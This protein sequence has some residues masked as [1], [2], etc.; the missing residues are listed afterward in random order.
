[1]LLKLFK[2]SFISVFLFS[3]ISY[4]STSDSFCYSQQL[5]FG[6]HPSGA[7]VTSFCF[8]TKSSWGGSTSKEVSQKVCDQWSQFLNLEHPL[9]ANSFSDSNKCAQA[10]YR[11]E[12]NFVPP[13]SELSPNLFFSV[14]QN[15]LPDSSVRRDR[16]KFQSHLIYTPAGSNRNFVAGQMFVNDGGAVDAPA[17]FDENG[18]E[19]TRWIL[20]GDRI[21]CGQ[22]QKNI[23]FSSSQEE[24]GIYVARPAA[25]RRTEAYYQEFKRDDFYI[26]YKAKTQLPDLEADFLKVSKRGRTKQKYSFFQN[27]SFTKAVVE[28]E[29]PY[30]PTEVFKNGSKRRDC[31]SL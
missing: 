17:Y 5:D 9:K 24:K 29:S 21:Y 13:Q 19:L 23:A 31:E 6:I 7:Y 18:E 20:I 4:G 25:G 10:L 26:Y 3:S 2:L 8:K 14:S 22:T 30:H 1:M 27:S 12:L 28:F 16:G 15:L 11:Q